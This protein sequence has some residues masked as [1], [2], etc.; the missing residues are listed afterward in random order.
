VLGGLGK[1]FNFPSLSPST[2]RRR[3]RRFY[4]N[5]LKRHLNVRVLKARMA[6]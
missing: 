6:Q 5:I 3:S 4:Q 2:C 1:D